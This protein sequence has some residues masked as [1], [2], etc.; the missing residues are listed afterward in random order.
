MLSECSLASLGSPCT[1]LEADDCKYELIA[2]ERCCC[3]R[4]SSWL[5]LA[6]V[7]DSTTGARLWQPIDSLC[8]A[9]GCGSE[10]IVSSPNY[11]DTYPNNFEK[12]ETIQVDSGKI[13]RLEFTHFDVD[14]CW[15]GNI[16]SCLCDFVKITDGDGTTLMDKSCGDSSDTSAWFYFPLPIVTSRSNRVDIFFITDGSN[17]RS[18]W[19]IS[20]SAVTPGN[21]LI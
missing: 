8:P 2:G 16:D 11:P 20:W 18:G 5:S 6:C 14:A 17:T 21:C 15:Y 19:S 13:L 12:T 7:L 10:G 3:G 1:N 4:C 9:E